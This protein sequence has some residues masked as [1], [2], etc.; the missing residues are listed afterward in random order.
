[1]RTLTS[2]VLAAAVVIAQPLHAQGY[3][4]TRS[5]FTIS[6]GLGSGSATFDCDGCDTGGQTGGS[7]YLRIGGAVRPSLIIAGEVN[8]WTKSQDGTTLSVTGL[9]AVAQWY[10]NVTSGFYVLGGIGGGAI[11]AEYDLGTGILTETQ[12]G[13]SYQIGAGYDWR[14][15]RNF[16]LS[17][18]ASYLGVNT[19]DTGYSSG[20]DK[21]NA[22]VFHVGLGFTWH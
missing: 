3:P 18:Y 1:M 15:G 7:G 19:G 13:V 12:R 22:K 6:F 2:V 14:V 4:H 17:P 5:G 9:N 11:T 16:S 8:G 20:G 21:L 10:P